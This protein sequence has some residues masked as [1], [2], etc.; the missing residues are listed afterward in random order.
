MG[1]ISPTTAMIVLV[2]VFFFTHYMFASITAHVTAML[3][4]MLAVG[5]AS[6][7]CR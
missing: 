4:V 3:P 6:P 2:A 7:V 1:G 5:S